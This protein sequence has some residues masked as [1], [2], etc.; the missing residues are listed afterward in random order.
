MLAGALAN[1]HGNGLL[2]LVAAY[3]GD[4]ASFLLFAGVYNALDGTFNG[5]DDQV[6]GTTTVVLA[7]ATMLAIPILT[8]SVSDYHV[9]FPMRPQVGWGPGNGGMRLGLRIAEVKF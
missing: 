8:Y 9:R 2:T 4:L 3:G 7:S 6:L 5:K 1:K